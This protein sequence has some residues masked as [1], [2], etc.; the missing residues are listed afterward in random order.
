MVYAPEEAMK[1]L[2]LEYKPEVRS[3][4]ELGIIEMANGSRIVLLL[5]H[6]GEAVGIPEVAKHLVAVSSLGI[7]CATHAPLLQKLTEKNNV[8]LCIPH[9]PRLTTP[10]NQFAEYPPANLF[11]RKPV[12][13]VHDEIN[14]GKLEELIL[15][16][17]L[18]PGDP[19]PFSV[20][21]TPQELIF[22]QP[23]NRHERRKEAKMNRSKRKGAASDD[24][25]LFFPVFFGALL[26]IVGLVY[27]TIEDSKRA[28]REHELKKLQ[29]IASMTRPLPASISAE[30]DELGRVGR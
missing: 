20:D 19:P 14:Y 26:L 12:A 13:V 3:E 7:D 21:L 28:A 8:V 9:G 23:L 1:R 18:L 22:S 24:I 5:G 25:L 30:V 11:G 15:A 2:L 17:L 29:I 27:G 10:L 4:N 6:G 16:S